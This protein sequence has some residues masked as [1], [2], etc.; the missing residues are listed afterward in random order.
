MNRLADLVVEINQFVGHGSFVFVGF[1]RFQDSKHS[2]SLVSEPLL[3]REKL[4]TE[5]DSDSLI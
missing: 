5:I 3:F 1:E 4:C 2:F